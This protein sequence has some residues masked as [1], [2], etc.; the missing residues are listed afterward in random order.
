MI[1][2][3]LSMFLF[4]SCTESWESWQTWIKCFLPGEGA[5]DPN[6]PNRESTLTQLAKT[7]ISLSLTSKYELRE[8]E[9]Q[10]LKSLMIKY[11]LL[12]NLYYGDAFW[13]CFGLGIFLFGL[14]FFVW[15]FFCLFVC[16]KSCFHPAAL[17]KCIFEVRSALSFQK[18]VCV[19]S[20]SNSC[21]SQKK[22]QFFQKAYRKMLPLVFWNMTGSLSNLVGVFP[23]SCKS[24]LL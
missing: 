14:G 11:V 22:C 17:P 12:K 19:Q 6:D 1:Y 2:S 3:D 24:T 18:P 16:L 21:K 20:Y 15:G 23:W 7:E 5:V 9:D 4:T 8:G 13:F 10:D